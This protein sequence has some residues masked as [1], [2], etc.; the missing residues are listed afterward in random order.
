LNPKDS[1][2]YIG[3]A[4]FYV[5]Q[6]NFDKAIT[7]FSKAIEVNPRDWYS[8]YTRGFLYWKQGEKA[9]ADADCQKAKDLKV[10]RYFKSNPANKYCSL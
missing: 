2:S 3:R 5:D 4:L 7:D 9:K 6:Q 10:F 1:E 8:Y